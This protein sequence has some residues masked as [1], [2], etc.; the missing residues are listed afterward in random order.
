MY[1]RRMPSE[2]KTNW[3]LFFD[4][5]EWSLVINDKL[6]TDVLML[7]STF[8]GCIHTCRVKVNLYVQLSK[9]ECNI[10]DSNLS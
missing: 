9:F 10:A 5:N 3:T 1:P 2:E 7:Q 8:E 4:N 6:R